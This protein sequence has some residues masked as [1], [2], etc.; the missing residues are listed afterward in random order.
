MH[1]NPNTPIQDLSDFKLVISTEAQAEIDELCTKISN[2]EWSGTVFFTISGDTTN[3]KDLTITVVK[4][5]LQDIGSSTY[6]EYEFTPEFANFLAINPEL[7]SNTISGHIHSHH[8]MNT[9]FSGTDTKELEDSVKSLESGIFFSLIVNNA[10]EYTAAIALAI[11]NKITKNMIYTIP[12]YKGVGIKETKKVIVDEIEIRKYFTKYKAIKEQNDITEIDKR[13]KA[14]KTAKIAE[15]TLFTQPSLPFTNP[16]INDSYYK[17]YPTNYSNSVI[18]TS[19]YKGELS[20]ESKLFLKILTLSVVFEGTWEEAFNS[21]EQIP[22]DTYEDALD[23]FSE[24][25][26]ILHQCFNDPE[27]FQPFIQRIINCGEAYENL[28]NFY[29]E[30][31]INFLEINYII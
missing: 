3:M 24:L 5:F 14:I 17:Q 10:G 11:K 6:T 27:A 15:A 22:I 31:A 7:M 26:P 18:T 30:Q 4:I 23:I 1:T 16:Y 8:N 19:K 2:T 9:F 21:L 13:I 29:I 20:I 28:N 12:T 25:T